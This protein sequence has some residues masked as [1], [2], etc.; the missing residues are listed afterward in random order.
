[1]EFSNMMYSMDYITPSH[2][3]EKIRYAI[4]EVTVLA[5]KLES[6]GRRVLYLNIGDPNVYDFDLVEEAKEAAIWAI[7]NHKNGYAAS[8][9]VAE[10]IEAIVR[11]AG[12]RLHIRN[13]LGCYT[14]HGA[15][16]CIDIALTALVNPGDNVLLPSPTYPLY[17]NVLKRLGA[18]I[19]YYRLDSGHGWEPDLEQMKSLIDGRTRGV[20]VINPN[21]PTGA[22]YPESVLRGIIGIAKAHNLL[23]FSDEI[24]ER[25]VL[26]PEKHHV[27]MA[28]LDDEACMVTFDGMSKAFLGPG[29][30]IGW[31]IVTGPGARLAA[32][33]EAIGHLVRARLCANHPFQWAVR[34]CLEGGQ[35][36][37]PA[38]LDKLRRRRDLVLQKI[39]SIPGLS[40]IVPEGSFY[41][42]VRVEGAEDDAGW[43]RAL[44]ASKGVVVV[45]GSGF[46]YRELGAGYF[47]IV[48]LPTE[49]TL[50][51]AFDKIAEFVE[52]TRSGGGAPC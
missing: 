32:Y 22:I 30:R 40:C 27:S 1:M 51:E 25:L 39:A 17:T 34:P 38:M 47:R 15:S 45:P 2:A 20:V 14:G 36:H 35:P 4:R 5:R 6:E 44:L 33:R 29:I 8:E 23:V 11:D 24:Y 31:G 13:I 7:R 21:N 26:S 10:A 49:D 19:R 42:F 46:G 41:A 9:G 43:C 18:E 28:A 48:F 12:E 50:A 16:E 37:L 52:E 3:T